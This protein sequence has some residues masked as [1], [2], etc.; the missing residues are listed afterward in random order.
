M[1]KF[2]VKQPMAIRVGVHV[3][4][5]PVQ[6]A[7]CPWESVCAPIFR[8]AGFPRLY[9]LMDRPDQLEGAGTLTRT[10]SGYRVQF[11]RTYGRPQAELWAAVSSPDGLDSWYPTQ[12]RTDGVVGNPVTE[13]FEG[14]DGAREAA[15]PGI[16]TEYEPPHLFEYRIEGPDEAPHA[17][18]LGTQ[19]IRMEAHSRADTGSSSLVFTHDV[20][21]LPTA[22][23]VLGGWHYCLEYLGRHLESGREPTSE[24][25][26]RFRGYYH[27]VFGDADK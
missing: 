5:K 13:T 8:G 17:G 20:E 24:D 18:M 7:R 23:D 19:T 10:E 3:S 25:H 14:E 2:T 11:R 22:L 16:L 21:T 1:P 26:E 4:P 27:A 6:D 9:W 12:L 15:P